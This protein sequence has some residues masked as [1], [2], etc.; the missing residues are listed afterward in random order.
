[1]EFFLDSGIVFRFKDSMNPDLHTTQAGT[2]T[3]AYVATD[4]SGLAATSTRTVIVVA[5]TAT[6]TS[7]ISSSR[8]GSQR[9]SGSSGRG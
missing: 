5:P 9:E 7:A 4:Q 6:G 2:D 8:D 1:M 3:V